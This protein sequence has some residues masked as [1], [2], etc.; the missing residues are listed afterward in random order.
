LDDDED[1]SS[2]GADNMDLLTFAN[3]YANMIPQDHNITNWAGGMALHLGQLLEW[4]R[5]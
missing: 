4:H 3:Y 1:D 5:E 2:E